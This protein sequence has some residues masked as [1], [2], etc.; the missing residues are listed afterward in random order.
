MNF[1]N[2]VTDCPSLPRTALQCERFS[3]HE[4]FNTKTKKVLN[5]YL[6]NSKA[7]KQ[8]VWGLCCTS[9]IPWSPPNMGQSHRLVWWLAWLRQKNNLKCLPEVGQPLPTHSM[10]RTQKPMPSWWGGWKVTALR[11]PANLTKPC[12]EAK[13]QSHREHRGR[14]VREHAACEETEAETG[15][16]RETE[17][18]RKRKRTDPRFTSCVSRSSGQVTWKPFQ[19]IRRS[20][21]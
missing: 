5:F 21:E 6:Q 11:T 20:A 3:G 8:T 14:Q 13:W 9:M 2:R 16:K 4:I 18:Q 12:Q 19:T 17:R 7:E 15:R 1:V 10:E